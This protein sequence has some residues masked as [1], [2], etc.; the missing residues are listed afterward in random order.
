MCK[1]NR[2]SCV[3]LESLDFSHFRPMFLIL[4][5]QQKR[6]LPRA[7]E[8]VQAEGTLSFSFFFCAFP[9]ASNFKSVARMF[10][11]CL[12]RTYCA[13]PL[14]LTTSPSSCGVKSATFARFCGDRDEIT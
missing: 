13:R 9:V 10:P 14:D 1:M 6:Q 12:E 3:G 7:H 11:D 5:V 8:D 4:R 2:A